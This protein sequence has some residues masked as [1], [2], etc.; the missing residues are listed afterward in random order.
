MAG[1][2]PIGLTISPK[3]LL[4]PKLI[5]TPQLQAAIKLLAMPR[6]E[7]EQAIEKEL[8]ENP[9]L[10]DA[11]GVIDTGPYPGGGR[12]SGGS[13]GQR[14]FEAYTARE[15]TLAEHVLAQ[16]LDAFDDRPS[17]QIAAVLTGNLDRNGYLAIS[18][19]EAAALCRS[20]LAEVER[21][22]AVMQGFDPPGIC[23]R[24]LS[25][26][27]LIQTERKGLG[28]SLVGK[29]IRSHLTDLER[30]NYRGIV[31]KTR[32][33]TAKVLAAVE[34]I[35]QLEPK[36]G[37]AFYNETSRYVEPDLYV[38]SDGDGFKV[39]LNERGL[40]ALQISARYRSLLKKWSGAGDE[41]RDYLREKLKAAQWF[42]NSVEQR[43]RTIRRVMAAIVAR[44]R[45]FFEQG[46]A[47]LKPMVL[48]DIAGEIGM[49]ESTVS[50][51]IS[52]KYVQTP[53]GL[54][55]L[56]SF[57]S[58]ALQGR[59]GGEVSSSVA[60]DRVGALVAAEDKRMPLSDEKIARRLMEEGIHLARR[61]VAKYREQ[62]GILP[63][64]RRKIVL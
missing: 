14:D 15:E 12:G 27:L 49:V 3:P 37:R 35:R 17:R 4:A 16:V 60:R 58:S 9:L 24:D 45:G 34:L 50:R 57:F 64:S 56:K 39:F 5:M 41:E 13:D 31:K 53:H 36:P 59:N 46:R 43:R 61:T 28:E 2:P 29:I 1:G 62:L 44:Q 52:D 6:Q 19:A 8:L 11:G 42:I 21:V 20:F 10:E 47:H 38:T 25:E 23:A 22:L 30:G 63:S 7:L 32:C 55:P 48:K 26:C 54:I 40:P 51:A 18:T 33:S